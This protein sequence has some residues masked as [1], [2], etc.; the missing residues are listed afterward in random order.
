MVASKLDMWFQFHDA[1]Q[2]A[3]TDAVK[4]AEEDATRRR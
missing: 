4:R 2:Q 3:E 1:E